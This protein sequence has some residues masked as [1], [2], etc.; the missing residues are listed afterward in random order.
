MAARSKIFAAAALVLACL[1]SGCPAGEVS[2]DEPDSRVLRPD[3]AGADAQ[4]PAAGTDAEISPGEDAGEPDAEGGRDAGRR[5]SSVRDAAEQ[6]GPDASAPSDPDAGPDPT[7]ASVAP[8]D[9]GQCALPVAAPD[10]DPWTVRAPSL[11]FGGT[12]TQSSGGHQDVFLLNPSPADYTRIGAR[13]DWGGT[14]VFYGLSSSAATNVIDANDTGR[15]LQIAIYDPQRNR[16]GC[17]FDATCLTSSINCGNSITFLGWN[18]VQGGDEC[19]R[20]AQASWSVVGDALRLTVTPVQWNPDWDAPDCRSTPCAGGTRPAE[21]RYTMDLRYVDTHVVE[22]ALEV[23]SQETIDHQVTGQEFPTLYVSHGSGGPDLLRLLD[24]SGQLVVID[25][26]ANDGF[27]VKNFTSPAPWVAFQDSGSTYGVG[28]GMDQG[29]RDWQGWAGD[30]NSAP[31]FHNVR[32]QIAFGL[33]R[34]GAVRGIAY[35]AL[36]GFGT[37]QSALGS[38]L[39]HRPPFGV[40]DAPAPG[41]VAQGA[42]IPVGG[43][44]LDTAAIGSVDVEIDGA[45]AASLPV[46]GARSDVCAVYPAYAGCP[47]VG[48]AGAISTAGL[49][50]CVHLMR[51]VATDADGNRS[52]LGERLIRR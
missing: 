4:E 31:Y 17:A 27:T 23:L 43:W 47:N 12:V 7:D 48:Y 26:P 22:V 24:A 52:V 50:G 29:L 5:D 37:V 39:A 38:V 46:T 32:A 3:A 35:L 13:L 25:Q 45:L 51:V 11:G 49:D 16:Q 42:S 34:G 21:V 8:V 18:P 2:S 36:G 15:E 9:V 6:P 33:P 19:N 41:G 20:G 28:L 30:G 14:I 40:V 44:V 1:L 10:L